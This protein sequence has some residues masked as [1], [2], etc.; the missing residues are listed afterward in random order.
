MNFTPRTNSVAD[1]AQGV[2]GGRPPPSWM[3]IFAFSCIFWN[4]VKL[5]PLFSAKM[6]LTPSLLAH[7]GSATANCYAN[8]P[9]THD[10]CIL[11]VKP[12]VKRHGVWKCTLL[13]SANVLTQ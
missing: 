1:P 12:A 13:P 7:S 6:W 2:P 4:K 11:T 8:I 10:K 5:T 3:K 9:E